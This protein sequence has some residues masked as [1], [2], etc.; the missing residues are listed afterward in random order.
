MLHQSPS[1]K[2]EE[3]RVPCKLY[4]W[5]LVLAC[6][7]QWSNLNFSTKQI[8]TS[9]SPSGESRITAINVG[10]LII[11]KPSSWDG[12]FC[13]MCKYCLLA[14]GWCVNWG[15]WIGN[16]SIDTAINRFLNKISLLKQI[17]SRGGRGEWDKFG[18]WCLHTTMGKTDSQGEA[19]V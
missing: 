4:A 19:A 5:R 12:D 2:L 16:F 15:S 13:Q 11:S 6:R 18:E 7:G 14:L 1:L 17:A 10:P 8:G 3:L 9:A